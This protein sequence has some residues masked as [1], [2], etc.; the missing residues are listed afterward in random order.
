MV[1][2]ERAATHRPATRPLACAAYAKQPERRIKFLCD[3]ML[4]RPGQWLRVA[5]YDVPMLPDG[6]YDRALIQRAVEEHRLPVTRGREMAALANGR[7]EIASIW[8]TV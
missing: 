6:T 3:E 7:V 1:P 4:K 5:G 2:Q 8:K